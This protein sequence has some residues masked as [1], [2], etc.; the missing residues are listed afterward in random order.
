MTKKEKNFAKIYYGVYD[1]VRT[2]QVLHSRFTHWLTRTSQL[3]YIIW[4]DHRDKKNC[5]KAVKEC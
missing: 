2:C 3:K 1:K 4:T 5:A